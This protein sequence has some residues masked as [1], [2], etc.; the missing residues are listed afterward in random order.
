MNQVPPSVGVVTL[1]WNQEEDTRECLASLRECTY[2]DKT[3]I[4]VDN[5]SHDGS[6]ARLAAMFPEVQLLSQPTNLGFAEGNNVGI[7]AAL[8]QGA[9][10][11][12]LLNNDTL[13]DKGFLEPLVAA[14]DRHPD[15]GIVGSKIYC[16][17]ERSILWAAGARID[18]ISGRQSH[19]G[20]NEE[21]RGQYDLEADV[22]YVSACCLLARREVF[23]QVG[24]LDARYFI[25]FEETAWNVR[26][27]AHGF[28]IRY[29]PESRIWHKVSA[30]MNAS[31]PNSAYYLARN[32][33]LFLTENGP[34]HRRAFFRYFYTTRSL[35]YGF[36]LVASGK[37]LH[38]QAVL[39]GVWDFYRNRLGRRGAG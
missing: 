36:R 33:L 30:A 21:D 3:V 20:T 12:L 5:G 9:R 35:W 11:I 39:Q 10:Y 32:R 28:G 1:N 13:V 6:P 37:F 25:Y 19:I 23:E 2:S 26:A 31:S 22:D 7:R 14:L 8:A 15:V 27:R 18:W 24:L 34:A 29:I 38:G 17:P 4:L 16:Y